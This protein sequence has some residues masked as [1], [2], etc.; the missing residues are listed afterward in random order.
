MK[1]KFKQS[2]LTIPPISTKRKNYISPQIIEHKNKTM[3]NH[4]GN[5]GLDFGHSNRSRKK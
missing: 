4:V 5:P 2:S 1:I 3:I